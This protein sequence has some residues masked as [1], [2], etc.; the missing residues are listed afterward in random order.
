MDLSKAFDMV[1]W[2][3]LFLTLP[4]RKVNPIFLRLIIFI[5]RNQQCNVKWNSSLSYKLP[6]SHG[7]RQGAVSSPIIFSIYINDLLIIL[8]EAG[9]GCHV[10]SFFVGCLGYADDLLILSASRSGLQ[11]MVNI[12]QKFT[13]KK[14][15]KFSTNPGASKSKTK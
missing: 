8:R 12:C 2:E 6:V 10:G 1:E 14:N 5:Y 4:K 15:L 11:T 3:E 13:E 7:V 9:F